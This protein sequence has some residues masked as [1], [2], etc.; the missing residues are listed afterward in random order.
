MRTTRNRLRRAITTVSL[1]A[2][3]GETWAR[4]RGR[5]CSLMAFLPGAGGGRVCPAAGRC[6]APWEWWRAR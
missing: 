5:E 3:A 4:R 2:W 1:R 6:R